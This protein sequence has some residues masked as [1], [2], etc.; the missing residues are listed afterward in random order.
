MRPNNPSTV[1]HSKLPS[2]VQ[3]FQR[4]ICKD[5]LCVDFCQEGVKCAQ[6]L[7]VW[8][9]WG[10]QPQTSVTLLHQENVKTDSLAIDEPETE[11]GYCLLIDFGNP[12]GVCEKLLLP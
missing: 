9:K 1:F 12:C 7:L 11:Q 6:G 4:N 3:E 2:T 5:R 8:C 10:F